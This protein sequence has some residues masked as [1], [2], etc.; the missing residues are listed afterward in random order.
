[1]SET[2]SAASFRWDDTRYAASHA[3]R[4]YLRWI[5]TRK[6]WNREFAVRLQGN[7]R[8]GSKPDKLDANIGCPLFVPKADIRADVSR[9]RL[10]ADAQGGSSIF[11]IRDKRIGKR[12]GGS[13]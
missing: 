8:L 3:P 6:E 7:V 12:Q 5:P 1:M 11:S 13:H 4:S 2:S 10:G 9:G